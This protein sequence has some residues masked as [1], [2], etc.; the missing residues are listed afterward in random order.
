[1]ATFGSYKRDQE[2]YGGYGLTLSESCVGVPYGGEHRVGHH[3]ELVEWESRLTSPI[4]TDAIKTP[5]SIFNGDARSSSP[6]RG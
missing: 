3:G 2:I 5:Y 4:R 6:V 1:M